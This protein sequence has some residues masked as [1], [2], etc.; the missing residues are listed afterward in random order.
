VEAKVIV[1][2]HPYPRILKAHHNPS[3]VFLFSR[4]KLGLGTFIQPQ[5][6]FKKSSLISCMHFRLTVLLFLLLGLGACAATPGSPEA[7][8]AQ[9]RSSLAAGVVHPIVKAYADSTQQYAVYLPKSY[10]HDRAYGVVYFFDA[11]GRGENPVAHYDILADMYDLIIVGSWNSRNGQRPEEGRAIFKQMFKDTREKFNIDSN[12]V[13]LAGFSGGARVAA[14][15]AQHDPMIFAVGGCAAGFQ[16]GMQDKFAFIGIVGVEDFNFQEMRALDEALD[17]T[18]IHHMF[19]YFVGGH[20]WPDVNFVAKMFQFF[21]M[22]AMAN[23]KMP[24][25]E[26]AVEG[27]LKGYNY[28]DSLMKATQQ[29]QFRWVLQRKTMGYLTGVHDIAPMQA[30][31]AALDSSAQVRA[32]RLRLAQEL[33]QELAMRQQYGSLLQTAPAA[34]WQKIGGMLNKMGRHGADEA[35]WMYMRVVNYLSLNAFLMSKQALENADLVAAERLISI[36]SSIDPTNSEHAYLRGCLLIRKNDVPGALAALEQSFSLG[37]RDWQRLSSV[38]D[39][40]AISSNPAFLDL[41][42]RMQTVPVKPKD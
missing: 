37:N 42:K 17:K 22:R 2:R 26:K 14:D 4:D 36:Y 31:K 29:D 11:Q 21:Q 8:A 5:T 27:M 16:P 34:Q 19:E 13:A 24:K 39:F 25:S 10:T 7:L 41:V 12:R 18:S 40:A 15:I 33:Q 3:H 23:G 32:E 28:Q 35:A 30:I 6:D 20:D 9:P 38:P 1:P